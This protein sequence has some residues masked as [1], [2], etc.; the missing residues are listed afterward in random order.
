MEEITAPE[1]GN[2]ESAEPFLRGRKRA[3][4]RRRGSRFVSRFGWKKP[5]PQIALGALVLLV[6]AVVVVAA[7]GVRSLMN[8]PR[9]RLASVR[10]IQIT[11]TRVVDPNQVLALFTPDIGHSIFHVPLAA[12]QKQIEQIRWVRSAAVM[13]IW[14]GQIRVQIVERAP[15]AFAR[16]ANGVHLIDPD[17]VL[18]DLPNATA[19]HYSFPVLT[20]VSSAVPLATRAA[21]MAKYQQ[22]VQALNHGGGNIASGLSEVDLSDPEDLRA[23]FSGN[24]RQPLVHF[25]GNDFLPRYQAYQAHLKEWLQQ[26]PNLQSVDMRYGRQVV[27]GTGSVPQPSGPAPVLNDTVPAPV[28]AAVPVKPT[29]AVKATPHGTPAKTSHVSAKKSSATGP[30]K[31]KKKNAAKH[32]A[33]RKHRAPA[34][35]RGH[36]VKNPIMHTVTGM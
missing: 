12:R 26:Y 35:E 24:G 6:V 4:V 18:L 19:Q 33:A 21:R 31:S 7:M 28:P 30:Q 34:K 2:A 15:I 13:R 14:P 32:P 22:F 1:G 20:G 23:I 9:F 27:L 8:H 25:G 5:W 17:G 11:G 29:A 36:P 10:E 3:A 16:D